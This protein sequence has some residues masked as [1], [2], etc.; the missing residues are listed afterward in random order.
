MSYSVTSLFCGAGGLDLGFHMR[1]FQL[2]FANDILEKPL[3]SYSK[4]LGIKLSSKIDGSYPLAVLSD[5]RDLNFNNLPHSDVVIGGPPCQ[6]FS[7][8]RGRKKRK[9]IEVR[10]GR[11]Y[12]EF[13]R[14]LVYTQ[15][16]FFVFEN[17]PGLL[18]ANQGKA[19]EVIENDF[20]NLPVEWK[21]IQKSLNNGYNS[22]I[23]GY[24]LLFNSVVNM[25]N[26]GVPQARKR[27]III[28][29]RKDLINDVEDI[30][31]IKMI[32]DKSLYGW[33]NLFSK[34]PLTPIEV[35][36]GKSL[37]KL[38]DQYLEVM[39]KYDKLWEDINNE[40]AKA[41]KK[42]V[43]DNLNFDIVQD[44][45]LLNKIPKFEEKEFKKAMIEHKEVLKLLKYYKRPVEGT[46]F[47]DGSNDIPNESDNIKERLFR[48][49]PGYNY[50]FVRG[51][52]WSV[53]G[54]MSGV[55]RRIHPLIPS[56]T[57]IAYGGGGTWG[58]HYDRE[59]G[60]MTNRER[61]RIQTFPDWYLFEGSK[62][63]V[64][65][66]IGEAVPPLAS[67]KIAGALQKIL[68]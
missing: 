21:D 7:V 13:V 25:V 59:R 32:L 63:D 33:D 39:T 1:E 68:I 10:R 42:E 28:G 11:L 5:V 40:H 58:Y 64:R 16:K 45:I 41:W 34:Y 2:V 65:A 4:N 57:I 61:A 22:E 20:V 60:M 62:Q 8:L 46:E 52:R 43:W 29:V 17:V 24:E 14:A 12:S 44:Y 49:P 51:T 26:L 38:N 19:H 50:T 48:I 31:N 35:F 3:K 15:P 23:K 18:T 6:D 66:Q 54:L 56:P 27:L 55:Y 37:D 36:E 9:G 30:Y 67:Y 53:K 47:E